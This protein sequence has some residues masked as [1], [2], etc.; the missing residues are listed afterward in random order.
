M[1][2]M[3]SH[4]QHPHNHHKE[5]DSLE[6]EH[7][8]HRGH[9]HHG[10]ANYNL[11]FTIGMTLNLG[12]VIVEVI[13][14]IMAHSVALLADGGHNLSDVLGLAL[15]WG[16][17]ILT[18]RQPTPRRTY[19]W[20]RTSILTAF[21]NAMFLLTVTGGIAWEAIQRLF[22]P[23]TT[24]QAETLI[25]VATI[26]IAIN[27]GTALMFLAGRKND[28]NIRAAFMHM[29]ADAMVSAGVVVAGIVILFTRW[30]WLDPAF[31]L[32]VSA[33]IV[34]STWDLL[35]ES[36]HLAIDGVPK[37]IDERA[38]KHYLTEQSGVME[39]HDLH[40][41]GMSTTESALTVHLKMPSGHPGDAFLVKLCQDLHHLFGID[42]PTIQVELGDCA[43]DCLFSPDHRV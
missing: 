4:S 32:I 43:E 35:Q 21:F 27:T 20:R 42:H 13:Y 14:G 34:F 19:G 37:G 11:A 29:A 12:F 25:W 3:H 2:T 28:I 30:F 16:A 8:N 36:F 26:G 10:P 9:H 17:S 39:V 40:I 5:N 22:Y 18:R 15:A 7:H 6:N 38:V 41:W 23:D 33:L 31:S 24:V 1:A